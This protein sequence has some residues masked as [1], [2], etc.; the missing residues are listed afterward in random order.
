MMLEGRLVPSASVYN[1]VLEA[2]C[3]P[4]EGGYS[5]R[6]RLRDSGPD[7]RQTEGG[8]SCGGGRSGGEEELNGLTRARGR[9][10]D[11]GGEEA[12]GPRR[13][14]T[15]AAAAAAKADRVLSLF[16]EMWAQEVPMNGVTYAIVICALLRAEREDEVLRL[17]TLAW[18][19]PSAKKLRRDMSNRVLGI[20]KEQRRGA[21]A[22]RLLQLGARLSPKGLKDVV[23]PGP[24]PYWA[25]MEACEREGAA[26]WRE[27]LALVDKRDGS[28]LPPDDFFSEAGA[29]LLQQAAALG[30]GDAVEA[31]S[32]RVWKKREKKKK[33]NSSSGGGGGRRVGRFRAAAAAAAASAAVDQR[34]TSAD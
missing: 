23:W 14:T 30:I 5:A 19:D 34:A 4:S 28:P 10:E 11:G 6:L 21:L 26:A 31:A 15:A 8:G 24:G 17:W 20:C 22:V 33:N 1:A 3:P 18:S 27:A 29:G 7:G 9:G 16:E 2:I 32:T 13:D 12:A 25:A